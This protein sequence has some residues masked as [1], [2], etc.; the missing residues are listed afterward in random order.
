MLLTTIN[1]TEIDNFKKQKIF[2]KIKSNMNYHPIIIRCHYFYA[3]NNL[4]SYCSLYT[5]KYSF[6]RLKGRVE[7]DSPC[8]VMDTSDRLV[9]D[10]LALKPARERKV[11]TR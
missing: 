10:T 6:V 4:I 7:I 8:E 1:N 5:V 11:F 9:A 2:L 3:K